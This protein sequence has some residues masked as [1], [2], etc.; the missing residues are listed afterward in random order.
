[1]APLRVTA[2]DYASAHDL[3]RRGQPPD[4]RILQH[5]R[6]ALAMVVLVPSLLAALV[7]EY[8]MVTAR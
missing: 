5:L 2:L 7:I 3:P 6:V 8:L 1:M 4:K